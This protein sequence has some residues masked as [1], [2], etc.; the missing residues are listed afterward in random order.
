MTV[1]ESVDV[2][3]GSTLIRSRVLSLLDYSRLS[4]SAR[5]KPISSSDLARR[6]AAIARLYPACGTFVP[7]VN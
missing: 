2:D 4:W 3:N 7:V 6:R 5:S 1:I